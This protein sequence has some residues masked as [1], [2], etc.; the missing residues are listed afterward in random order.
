V[1]EECSALQFVEEHITAI[2]LVEEP[3][4]AQLTATFAPLLAEG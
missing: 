2:F 3:G 4:E 1:T